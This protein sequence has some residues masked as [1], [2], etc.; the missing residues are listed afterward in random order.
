[1]LQWLRRPSLDL[2]AAAALRGDGD[3]GS[4][5]REPC[6]GGRAPAIAQAEEE[7]P[8]EIEG[9]HLAQIGDRVLGGEAVQA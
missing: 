9:A 2:S 3:F 5:S 1:M 7:I 8:I 4:P 6:L